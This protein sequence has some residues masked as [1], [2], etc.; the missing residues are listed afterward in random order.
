MA[1]SSGAAI[2]VRPSPVILLERYSPQ[3]LGPNPRTAQKY[4]DG[5]TRN[6]LD[7]L[8]EKHNIGPDG[9]ITAGPASYQQS[10]ETAFGR[11]PAVIEFNADI[12][13]TLLLAWIFMNSISFRVVEHPLFRLLL[14]Y[15]T[16]CVRLTL[17]SYCFG[18]QQL[19]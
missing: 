6:P 7:H 1:E 5:S 2:D 19:T 16:A 15:L 11:L 14:W 4:A 3:F 17:I 9:P 8:R 13:K 12:F 18:I 10:I